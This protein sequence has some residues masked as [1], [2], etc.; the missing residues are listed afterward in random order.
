MWNLHYKVKKL[1]L[2]IEKLLD[3]TTVMTKVTVKVI[4]H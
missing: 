1:D 4:D 2:R 3:K